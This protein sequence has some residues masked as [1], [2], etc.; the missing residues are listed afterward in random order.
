MYQFKAQK[1]K[2]NF[3]LS[4][5]PVTMEILADQSNLHWFKCPTPNKCYNQA[6]SNT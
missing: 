3:F 5:S 2:L 4:K 6:I 1:I